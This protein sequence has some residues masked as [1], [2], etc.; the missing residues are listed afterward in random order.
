MQKFTS[1]FALWGA[2]SFA[3]AVSF[4]EECPV[5][6]VPIIAHSGE[7]VGTEQVYEGINMYITGNASETAVLYLTD[8][9]G[10]DL[11][12][13]KLLADSFGRA[14]YL[15]VAPD[16][17][18]GTSAP[19]D[20]DGEPDF[21]TT[22]FLEEHDKEATDPIIATAID[23][24]RNEL[25]VN[26]VVA[27]GYCFGGR[28]TFRVLAEGN[29]VDAGF[30]AHP[31]LWED[32]E[33]SAIMGPVSIAAADGDNANPPEARARIETL[34]LDNGVP[35]SMALYGGTMHGFGVR[36]NVSDPKQKF[37]KEEAF[38]QAIRWFNAWA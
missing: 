33:I 29:G 38:F 36:A 11:L 21:N 9:F 19:G 25:G 22:K 12:E 15:T 23:F 28:Y 4:Q 34:L 37:G 6:G 16:L 13:N 7:P 30:A 35:Y 2:S 18:N 26:K 31:S 10:L 1:I 17:F 8:I 27:T 3:R 32:T 14:G 20:I 5:T 24:M